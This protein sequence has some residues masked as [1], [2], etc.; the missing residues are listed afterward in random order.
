MY[1]VSLVFY[2]HVMV[3]IIAA[4]IICLFQEVHY[5][6]IQWYIFNIVW[7]Y[8]YSIRLFLIEAKHRY[9]GKNINR[10]HGSGANLRQPGIPEG[11]SHQSA[12]VNGGGEKPY[13]FQILLF[14][15]HEMPFLKYFR[16][17]CA[18]LISEAWAP[19]DHWA[20][21]AHVSAEKILTAASPSDIC[22]WIWYLCSS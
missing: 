9:R 14:L 3:F 5:V 6:L 7:R 20:I 8:T 15:C 12:S 16:R 18:S 21:S 19:R 22:R 4:L 2:I 1:N 17:K 10:K 11:I 13:I